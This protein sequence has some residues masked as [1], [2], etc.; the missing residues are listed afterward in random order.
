MTVRAG[1]L[2]TLCTVQRKSAGVDEIG[3]PLPE[4]WELERTVWADVRNL[5]G[6]EAIKSGANVSTVSASIRIR[7]TT[8]IDAGMRVLAGG[9]VYEIK[10][11]L[12]DMQRREFVDLVAEVVT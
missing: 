2:T 11:V 5:N 1:R 12:P 10:V 3:Q 7:W 4:A 9:V 8:G 6:T